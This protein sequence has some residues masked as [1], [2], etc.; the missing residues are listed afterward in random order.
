MLLAAALGGCYGTVRTSFP[1]DD[2]GAGRGGS[3]G[4][5]S[6]GVRGIGGQSGTSG[7]SGTGTGTA[8]GA[9]G[10]G[11][12]NPIFVGGPC[13][14]STDLVG[15]DV[16]GRTNDGKIYRRAYDGT[17]WTGWTN[18]AALDGSMIDARSDLDCSATP[19]SVHVVA[20]GRSPVGAL[21]HAFGFGDAYNPFVREVP[22]SA[23]GPSPSIAAEAD[24][25]FFL[26][27]SGPGMVEIGSTPS[28]STLTPIT[29]QIDGFVSGPDLAIQPAGGSGLHHY[30][31]FDGSGSLAIYDYVMSSEPAH[32]AP[33]VKL[34]PP[35]AA[36]AFSPAICTENG[37]FGL[38]SVNVVAV[39]GGRLWYA[40]AD[41]IMSQF[42]PWMMI[43]TQVSASP[44]C[45]VAGG[46][47]G[48]VHVVTLSS[49]GTVLD[50]AG[51]GT[52]WVTTDLGPP[53]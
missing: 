5:G 37:A 41:S 53:R 21:L 11:G 43:A 18:L 14:A 46:S 44:D 23:P 7:G 12:S 38:S 48:I 28:P 26:A 49:G 33:P 35:I 24:S 51:K 50:V 16:L 40:R 27:F 17:T 42:S 6:G 1:E 39:A 45:V 52:S 47:D 22:A 30:A 20:S 19:V 31:A 9:G 2:A 8:G 3:G 25:H 36:F 15:V 29:T 4:G 10:T 13:V 32:W 34:A